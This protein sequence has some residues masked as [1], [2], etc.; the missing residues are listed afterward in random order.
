[1]A[2]VEKTM[3]GLA[4]DQGTDVNQPIR[5][6]NTRDN[7]INFSSWLHNNLNHNKFMGASTEDP[8]LI[9][10]DFYNYAYR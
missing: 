5:L 9:S 2:K 8:M 4:T 6:P 1:M 7:Q 3:A 10:Q